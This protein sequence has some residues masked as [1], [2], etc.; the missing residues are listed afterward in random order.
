MSYLKFDKSLMINLEQSLSKEIL[1]VNK[2]GAYSYSTIV[3][4]NTRKFHGLLVI[5]L[6]QLDGGNHVMLSS[7][8]PT[9]IQR[10]AEF[11]LGL[12]IYPG[13]NYSPNGHK[14]IREYDCDNN[15]STIYRVGGVILS[16]DLIFVSHEN[17][18]LVRYTLLDAHSPTILRLRPFLAFRNTLSLCHENNQLSTGYEEV[19]NGTAFC[20]Y[21]GYPPLYMQLSKKNSFSYFPDWYRNIEY[22][23]EQEEGYPYQEDLFVPG[24]FEVPLKK[25]ESVIFSAGTSPV[26]PRKMK[27]LFNK[28]TSLR[29]PRTSFTNCLINA[30]YQ[31]YNKHED[32]QRYIIAGYPW[33]Y[34]SGQRYVYCL[35]W[36]YSVL[37]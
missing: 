10:G 21:P 17:R 23:R 33:F 5:P 2:S 22:V 30:A 31:F 11:N 19:E 15:P 26:S 4:C 18:V 27:L 9:V 35:A 3:D 24:Y 1:R 37:K 28:E 8:D 7:L 13:D 6:Y 12:H 29:T 14:Y 20:L 16:K 25:G 32:G 36:Y 34:I